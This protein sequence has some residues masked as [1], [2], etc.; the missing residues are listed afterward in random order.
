MVRWKHI[1]PFIIALNLYS[2]G[3]SIQNEPSELAV[4]GG[5]T[6]GRGSFPFAGKLV[7]FVDIGFGKAPNICTA[8]LIR[9]NI[10][11]TASHCIDDRYKLD[12]AT[13]EIGGEVFNVVAYVKVG[14]RTPQYFSD[15]TTEHADVALVRLDRP[16]SATPVRI[17]QGR[18][19]EE[20][21]EPM[22]AE[23]FNQQ[24]SSNQLPLV[25]LGFGS[26]LDMNQGREGDLGGQLNYSPI[27]FRGVWG[28]EAEDFV[29][30]SRRR[31]LCM[32]DSGGPLLYRE[33]NEWVQVAVHSRSMA[34]DGI[35]LM[36]PEQPTCS[37][38]NGASLSTNLR[39][40][41][42][43]SLISRLPE[44]PVNPNPA[45]TSKTR[46]VNYVE[47]YDT[48][49]DRNECPQSAVRPFE[50]VDICGQGNAAYVAYIN[51]GEWLLYDNVVVKPFATGRYQLKVEMA[52][53]H[54]DARCFIAYGVDSRD[55]ETTILSP[56][57]ACIS[58]TG[59]WE[60]FAERTF[61]V[62]LDAR[63]KA[64]KFQ[65]PLGGLNFKSFTIQ[66]L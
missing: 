46:A 64:I 50:G 22:G 36:S 53:G 27:N 9:N 62:D 59:G 11:L 23:T 65:F 8:T 56:D 18:A 26:S 1:W 38:S 4:M 12:S 28:P 37:N 49:A 45:Y 13:L 31:S 63:Y 57:V 66:S 10:A 14:N 47:A 24:I 2:C 34:A 42:I 5:K 40:V 51:P 19:L 52:S 6:D 43:G 16:S 41:D 44:A 25:A 30:G 35:E 29:V 60:K 54:Q 33:G 15:R 7:T 48:T 17:Y 32:G 21:L 39:L 20:I 3:D 58:N 55:R 61:E